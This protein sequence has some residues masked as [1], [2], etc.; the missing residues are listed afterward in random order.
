MA[1][2]KIKLITF[3][4]DD[5]VWP[6]KKVI[7]DAEKALWNFLLSKVP[8]LKDDFNE[9]K[10]NEIRVAL[11]ERNPEL[12]FDLTKFRKEVVKELLLSLGLD[13]NEA[14]YYSNE[15]FN[16]FFKARNKVQLY[17]DAK[18]ILERLN[19]K[20]FTGSLSNGNADLEI[21]GIDGFFDFIINSKDVSS[22]KPSSPH[23]L[24]GLETVSCKP[25]EALH[26][27]DCPVNDVGGAR[28]CNINTIWFNCEKHKWDEIFPCGLQAKN[29]KDLYE[30]ITK[31]FILEKKN[32]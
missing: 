16:E 26:I 7:L 18:T 6:N 14:I 10:I 1:R 13:A 29:W 24:K 19:K 5:T 8:K 15:S 27:G 31:N 12:K 30:I 2:K 23:F 20:V 11:I 28:N 25:E 21:I 32:V 22:N 17:K 3:D 9:N 4:L